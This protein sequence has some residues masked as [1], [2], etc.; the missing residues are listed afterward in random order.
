MAVNTEERIRG[1]HIE[2]GWR[3]Y[4]KSEPGVCQ[5]LS[6]DVAK[7]KPKYGKRLGKVQLK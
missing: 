1:S 3:I 6:G 4:G 5:T 7:A 2:T